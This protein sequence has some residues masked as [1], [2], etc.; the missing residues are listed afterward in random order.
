MDWI[1]LTVRG[2][3]LKPDS[4]TREATTGSAMNVFINWHRTAAISWDLICRRVTISP[5]T[6]PSTARSIYQA[7]QPTIRCGYLGTRVTW[8]MDSVLTTAWYL[9]RM[10]ATTIGG[11]A[12][13][14]CLTALDS[15]TVVAVRSEST[16]AAL[17]IRS[18]CNG[19]RH[20]L[21]LSTF[22]QQ[23]CGWRARSLHR[24]SR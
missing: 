13:V 23:G 8:E 6:G 18:G 1:S 24:L 14:L 15:G 7:R 17:G 21:E 16:I 4:A 12:T 9:P 5:G 19:C 2:R 22:I 3:S 10:T 20:R 11:M